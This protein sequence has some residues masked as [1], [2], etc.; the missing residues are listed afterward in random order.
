[1][2]IE[3]HMRC[4]WCTPD[5][6]KTRTNV[7]QSFQKANGRGW[8]VWPSL[9]CAG[10]KVRVTPPMPPWIAVAA[11]GLFANWRR[12]NGSESDGAAQGL[13]KGLAAVAPHHDKCKDGKFETGMSRMR[14]LLRLI[15]V[16]GPNS[17]FLESR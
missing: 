14:G 7:K 2:W 16:F 11:K 15:R 10:S 9:L 6:N 12:S 17:V 13:A 5:K 1:M 4:C 8:T 3:G